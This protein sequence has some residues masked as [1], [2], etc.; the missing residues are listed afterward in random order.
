MKCTA[1]IRLIDF[2]STMLGL[3]PQESVKV[4]P[5]KIW[6]SNLFKCLIDT[7]L[8]PDK[9]GFSL[10]DMEVYTNLPIK[11]RHILKLMT[12]HLPKHVIE[13]LKRK[14]VE[15]IEEKKE[16]TSLIDYIDMIKNE[17][18]TSS[19]SSSSKVQIDWL[20]LSQLINGYE[21]LS[22]LNLY[23][24]S[25]D[26]N[27]ILFEYI[28]NRD[29]I[30]EQESQTCSEAKRK[31][32]NL[33][34]S[35]NCLNIGVVKSDYLI[36]II[37]KYI[38]ENKNMNKFFQYYKNE[39]FQWICKR[40][41][42]IIK[43]IFSKMS[44][45]FIKSVTL[46]SYIVDYLASEKN[47][48]KSYGTKLINYV[49][50]NWPLF[51]EFWQTEDN[52]DKKIALVGLLTKSLVIESLSPN[53]QYLKDISEMYMSFLIDKG[54]KL[55]QKIK[56]LD[57]LYFFCES[58]AP[59]QL[60]TYMAQF[61]VQLPLRSSE[62]VKGDNVYNDYLNCI[63]KILVSLELSQNQD[64]LTIMVNI[65]CREKEHLFESEIQLSLVRFIKR[66]ELKKQTNIITS[67]WNNGFRSLDVDEERKFIMFDKVIFEFLKNCFKPVFLE[68]MCLNIVY[69][70]DLLEVNLEE[71]EFDKI[72]LNKITAFQLIE[73]AY[74]RLH[75]DEIFYSTA[76]ICDCYETAK[77]GNFIVLN[78]SC[79]L[80]ILG[81]IL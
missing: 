70:I 25:M 34:I 17:N 54:L 21:Q 58:P 47:L 64:L 57:L 74:K 69:L 79:K 23:N 52:A 56:L 71:Q 1:L 36:Q 73:L 51:K 14:C 12:Q 67:Y 18:Q 49:Y 16:Y 61:I 9:V 45:N 77:F 53:S 19:N 7:C 39:I 11:T 42:P 81:F 66:L 63:R 20:K 13:N 72:C 24:F 4:I 30:N 28:L 78:L 31:L 50:E 3:Y 29:E 32:L 26:L 76:K 68:F 8:D 40:Y 35:L 38:F 75:K 27:R 37:D 65:L 6:S 33:T 43:Y 10:N 22:E 41:E 48:R 59:F 62:L 15:L 5:S 44:I 60:K 2:L 46:L 55:N 80:I